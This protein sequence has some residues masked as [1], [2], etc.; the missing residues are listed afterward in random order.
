M[1]CE[2]AELCLER[3]AEIRPGG[4]IECAIC[5]AMVA[6]FEGQN[7]GATGRQHRGFE[8]SFHRIAS[9]LAK[10]CLCSGEGD[11]TRDT[12]AEPDFDFGGVD[13]AHAMQELRGLR[14]D[15]GDHAGVI[16]TD[17]NDPE[18]GC[19]IQK[20]VAIDIRDQASNRMVPENR[21]I[22][23][24]ISNVRAF[25]APKPLGQLQ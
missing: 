15:G 5:Q 9:V 23:G 14:L 8:G 1:L 12:L 7:A 25:Y 10:N 2:A 21:E 16:M 11:E 24:E 6:I 22:G 17:P 18:G 20:A 13:I 4:D 3:A 19:D